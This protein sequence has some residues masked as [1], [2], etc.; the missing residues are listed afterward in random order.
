MTQYYHSF[1]AIHHFISIHFLIFN[2][3]SGI[4]WGCTHM[5]MPQQVWLYTTFQ[6]QVSASINR[7]LGFQLKSS[8]FTSSA[9]ICQAVL[10]ALVN[11]S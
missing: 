6:S 2:I 11:H 1:V 10:P 8:G 4:L 3:Y 9:F 7:I 5:G